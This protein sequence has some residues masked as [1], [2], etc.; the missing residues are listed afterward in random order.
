MTEAR[1]LGHIARSFV[2]PKAANQWPERRAQMEEFSS[3]MLVWIPIVYY[4]AL[5]FYVCVDQLELLGWRRR[6]EKE[7]DV[8]EKN[9]RMDIEL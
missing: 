6:R 1:C 9:V 8:V 5:Y 3:A 4:A 2:L 7:F